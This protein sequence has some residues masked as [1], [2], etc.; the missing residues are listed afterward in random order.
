MKLT[1]EQY[2]T[3]M[4]ILQ[5]FS[6]HVVDLYLTDGIIK[7]I[8]QDSSTYIS[9]NMSSL[10]DTVDVPE[11]VITNAGKRLSMMSALEFSSEVHVSEMDNWFIFDDLVSKLKFRKPFD[12]IRL[13]VEAQADI[14]AVHDNDT[15]VAEI[16]LD[17]VL[18]KKLYK[19][20][21]NAAMVYIM[22]HGPMNKGVIYVK[23]ENK[24]TIGVMYKFDLANGENLSDTG[25]VNFKM[26]WDIYTSSDGVGK[27]Q[28]FK[29]ADREDV[30]WAKTFSTVDTCPVEL[31][32]ACPFLTTQDEG[33][34]L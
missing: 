8:T 17:E 24:N 1:Q 15:L 34:E 11:I 25:V 26:P 6:K 5:H 10:F 4:N 30:F 21:D 33:I 9:C 2:K 22:L 29:P 20:S 23:T 31:T 28:I 18:V 16:E 19:A 12:D 32:Y 13:A 3:F 27:L 7:Q 14:V